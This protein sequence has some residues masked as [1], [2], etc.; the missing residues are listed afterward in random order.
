PPPGGSLTFGDPADAAAALPRP[1]KPALK[2][3]A[4]WTLIGKPLPRME[5]PGKVDGSAIFGM[6]VTVPGMVYAAVKTSPVFGGKVAH[7]D[8]ESISRLPGFVEV[9]EIPDGVAVVARSYWQ[10]RTALAAL[11]IE[12]GDRP[13]VSLG[14]EALRTQY[15]TAL[16][17]A[18]WHP[19]HVSGDKDAIAKGF[20][21]VFSQDYESQFL[22]HAT[23]EPMN[24]TAH[25]TADGCEVWAPSQGQELTQLAVSQVLSLPKEKV[26]IHRTLLG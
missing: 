17:R 24:C 1:E 9:V 25:V 21:T 11:R 6:D 5:N 16:A 19:P 15:R 20:A 4:D 23:M 2:R 3:P 26:K 13:N 7:Y 10:A 8:R 22:A 18:S 14:S 12:F